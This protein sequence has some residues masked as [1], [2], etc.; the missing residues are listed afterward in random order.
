MRSLAPIC[1]AALLCSACHSP[2][3]PAPAS[4]T[5][6]AAITPADLEKRLFIIAHDSMM[7]RET[8]SQG[9]Y[10]TADYVASE[11]RR[12]GL[13]P[14]GE[15]GTYF[16]TV[17]F[18]RVGV[19]RGSY[20]SVGEAPL[21]L[22]RDFLPT[23]QPLTPRNLDGV[24]AIYGGAINDTSHF[25][26]PERGRGHLVVLDVPAGVSTRGTPMN[27]AR[28]AGAAAI[29]IVALD[30]IAPEQIG[31]QMEGRPVLNAALNPA[32]TPLVFL[33]R[34]GATLVLG[35][36]PASLSTGAVGPQR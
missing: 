34:R 19:D 15:N 28:W 35:G 1:S 2:I 5:T 13:Q 25:I 18:Y 12:L 8:G 32:G 23:G 9:N 7:G 22:G 33:S 21:A 17:P 4:S 14:A 26:S 27:N 29:A 10:K 16:Q 24:T 6:V 31:R 11:F 36:A 20:I 3:H 30:Q